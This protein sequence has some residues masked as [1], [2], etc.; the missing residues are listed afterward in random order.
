MKTRVKSA[1]ESSRIPH[2]SDASCSLLH[3]KAEHE[4]L[5]ADIYAIRDA[6]IQSANQRADAALL[7]LNARF[8]PDHEAPGG[9]GHVAIGMC[10]ICCD[11]RESCEFVPCRHRVCHACLVRLRQGDAGRCGVV[12]PW[13]RA[14]VDSVIEG[15]E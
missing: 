6:E 2:A 11:A 9:L 15:I 1:H 7:R 13:D 12:C 3:E 14:S 10:E 5:K 8:N 4:Q